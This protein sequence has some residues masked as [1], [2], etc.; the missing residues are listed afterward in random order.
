MRKT[1]NLNQKSKTRLNGI[2]SFIILLLLIFMNLWGGY[3]LFSHG[4]W[5]R[6][7]RVNSLQ[8]L[9]LQPITPSDF[10]NRQLSREL[11]S[12]LND[13]QKQY[14]GALQWT[15]NRT[16]KI[17]LNPHNDPDSLLFSLENGYGA[18]CNDMAVIYQNSLASMGLPSRKVILMRNIFDLY[19]TH[20]TVEV[21]LNKKWVIM[22]P[23]FNVS[24]TDSRGTLL[25]AQEIKI[26][27]LKGKYRE[28]NPVFYG[29]TKYPARLGNYYLDFL[30]F[31]NNVFIADNDNPKWYSALPPF[32]YWFGPKIYYEKLP[33]E[34]DH[35]LRFVQN[36]YF[37]VIVVLPLGIAFCCLIVL[38]GIATKN[39]LPR[40]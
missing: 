10:Y 19:D 30:P 3:Q 16:D 31:Y 25:S 40:S 23:T 12:Q 34:S 7:V 5:A 9:P 29:E 38:L 20:T 1:N 36:F 8:T 6:L 24:F 35:H 17:G 37:I 39:R 13:P 2:G 4:F 22:D 18:M 33:A 14:L 27:F 11:F 28:I 21:K 32:R 15:M 26:F